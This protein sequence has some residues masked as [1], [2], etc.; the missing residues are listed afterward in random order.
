MLPSSV[1]ALA[2]QFTTSGSG[3]DSGAPL[4]AAVGG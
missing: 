4:S 1:L 3:P 2:S